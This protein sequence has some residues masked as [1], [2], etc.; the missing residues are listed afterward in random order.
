[1]HT[2][3]CTGYG[4]IGIHEDK[5]NIKG[6]EIICKGNTDQ[7]PQEKPRTMEESLQTPAK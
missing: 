5:E 3:F 4:H 1:M 7:W 6:I 2:E